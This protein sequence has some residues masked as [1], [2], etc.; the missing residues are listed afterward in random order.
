[1]AELVSKEVQ[2]AIVDK[3]RTGPNQ[4]EILGILGDV[5]GKNVVIIDDMIDTGGTIIKAANALKAEGAKKV[6]ISATHGIF[7]KGFDA[8]ENNDVIDKVIVTDSIPSVT[9]INL[10]N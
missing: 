7:S 5:K 4:S 9:K 10:I 2:I 8:F 3:R 6:V 1:M